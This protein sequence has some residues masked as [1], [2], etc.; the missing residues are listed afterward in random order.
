[1]W[2]DGDY[3][4]A[5]TNSWYKK[6]INELIRTQTRRCIEKG[7][8]IAEI[9]IPLGRGNC[10]KCITAMVKQQTNDAIEKAFAVN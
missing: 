3:R 1:M 6:I 10:I 9:T 4:F 7:E 5:T 2:S 8:A